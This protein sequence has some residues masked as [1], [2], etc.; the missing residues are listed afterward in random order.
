ML[1][2]K[3]DYI[4][5]EKEEPYIYRALFSLPLSKGDKKIVKGLRIKKRQQPDGELTKYKGCLES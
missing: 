5:E 2:Y 4:E 1:W 3:S